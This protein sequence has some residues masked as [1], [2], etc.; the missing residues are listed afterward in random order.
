MRV[1]RPSRKPTRFGMGLIVLQQPRRPTQGLP[2]QLAQRL[3]AHRAVD[4]CLHAGRR[5]I[6]RLGIEQQR[7]ASAT[8]MDQ[9]LLEHPGRQ[10]ARAR[11]AGHGQ[12]QVVEDAYGLVLVR[13]QTMSHRP[14]SETVQAKTLS[15]SKLPTRS[16]I[17]HR[18]AGQAFELGENVRLAVS[19]PGGDGF[20]FI[21]TV[22]KS[23]HDIRVEMARPPLANNINRALER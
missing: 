17:G 8:R 9:Q 11:F 1:A 7:T 15:P 13:V 10:R 14:F 23:V 18:R 5:L 6:D 21:Q 12:R 22:Q 3:A 2:F 16:S 19:V 4:L 20:E